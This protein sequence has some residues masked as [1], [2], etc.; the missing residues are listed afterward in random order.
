ML[1]EN[2]IRKPKASTTGYGIRVLRT[3]E[4]TYWS[5][6]FAPVVQVKSGV[7][8]CYSHPHPWKELKD[9]HHRHFN[10]VYLVERSGHKR[11]QVSSN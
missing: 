10:L 11:A 4:K 9:A 3:N 8:G 5:T 6:G 2:A 1:V 7:V